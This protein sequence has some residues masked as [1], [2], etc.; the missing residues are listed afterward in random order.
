[1]SKYYFTN[2]TATGYK[3]IIKT[4]SYRKY[5]IDNIDDLSKLIKR[6]PEVIQID[7]KKY[8]LQLHIMWFLPGKIINYDI[9]YTSY[10]A[11]LLY[12]I[13]TYED[14]EECLRD[15]IRIIKQKF[16]MLI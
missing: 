13:I 12:D 15:N 1:M 16:K 5:N 4:L 3:S 7:K 10:R 2:V 9:R 14:I 11:G 8:K 6:L